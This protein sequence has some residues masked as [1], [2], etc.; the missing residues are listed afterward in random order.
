MR[1][2]IDQVDALVDDLDAFVAL[3]QDREPGRPIVPYGHSLGGLATALY[4]IELSET[5]VGPPTAP[6]RPS[7]RILAT[8]LRG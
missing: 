4:A 1:I 8:A 6:L 3:V 2:Q 7:L 5:G